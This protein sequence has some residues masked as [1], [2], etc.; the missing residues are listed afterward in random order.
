MPSQAQPV[1]EAARLS[2]PALI[3]SEADVWRG[4]AH[5]HQGEYTSFDYNVRVGPGTDPGPGTPPEIRAYAERSTRKRIDVVAWAGVQPTI[6]EVKDRASASALGQ[7]LTY[8]VHWNMEHPNSPPAKLLLVARAL[9]P[10]LEHVLS[11]H[12]VPYELVSPLPA[13]G[14][15]P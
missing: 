8:Q 14:N 12:G 5:L 13:S 2:F 7:I 11:A 4:W 3:P 9:S 15:L 10:G 6:I 1:G